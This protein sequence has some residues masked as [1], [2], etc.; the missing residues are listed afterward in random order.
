MSSISVI[1]VI[2][3]AGDRGPDDPLAVSA[4]VAGKTLVPVAGVAMLTRVLGTL[5]SWERLNR[6]ILV[7]STD[8]AY[9]QAVTESALSADRLLWV[10]PAASLSDSVEK[11]LQAAGPGRPLIMATADH[12]LLD[13]AW[14]E[15][16]LGSDANADLCIGLAQWQSVMARFP[17]SRRT[18]YR[19]SDASV[20]GTNLFLFRDRRADD[21]LAT[22]RRVEQER[23]R[24]WRIIS[25]LGWAN[26]ARFLAG[27]LSLDRA[28]KA[29]SASVGVRVR[30]V[31]LADPLAAV[32]VDSLADL[33][34][35]EQVLAERSQPC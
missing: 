16:L 15:S 30:P 3:L 24:P 29:L 7:A 28:F 2:V 10:E 5:S 4:G 12:P 19:F 13:P 18:R 21:I 9:R 23:K 22:W 31:L 25:L 26:L 11:A 6:L 33:A 8:S 20:C 14:L 17:G 27:R 35:V 32:D 1:D 34:L